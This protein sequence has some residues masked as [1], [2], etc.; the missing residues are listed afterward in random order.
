MTDT[1][2]APV[3]AEPF[4]GTRRLRKEDPELLTGESRFTDDLV[5]HGALWLGIVRSTAAHARLTRIDLAGALEQPG[6]VAAYTGADLEAEW[7][8]PMPCA[9]PVTDDMKNP[10]HLPV[11][12]HK[13]CYVGDA[14]AVVVAETRS[15]A[16]DA[17]DHVVVEYDELPVV[18]DLEDAL[19][20]RAVIHDDLG[21]NSSYTWE[22]IPDADAVDRAFAEAAHTV[23][24]RYVQQR[25]LPSPMETRAVAVVPSPHGGD[26]V[27]YASTT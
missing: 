21:T 18:V 4:I 10:P 17:L 20:D 23:T 14:V 27:V 19:S 25:L 12:V 2:D 13:A 16:V 5:I 11:A 15:Q 6:V 22:L 3:A 1:I 9:W 26:Y 7:A 8:G 24:E